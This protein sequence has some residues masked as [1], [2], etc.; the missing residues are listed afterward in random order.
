MNGTKNYLR[1]PLTCGPTCPDGFYPDDATAT[2]KSCIGGC[3]RCETNGIN[4]LQCR[5]DLFLDQSLKRCVSVCPTGFFGDTTDPNSKIC[6]KCNDKC[7]SCTGSTESDC[8]SC[9]TYLGI[10]YF[11][12]LGVAVTGECIADCGNG[13]YGDIVT[14]RC[15]VCSGTCAKCSK[16]STNCTECSGGK[17]LQNNRCDSSCSAGF[18]A[19][20]SDCLPCRSDCATCSGGSACLTCKAGFAFS[21]VASDCVATGNCPNGTFE[22]QTSRVCQS[23]TAPCTHCSGNGLNCTLCEKG[24]S[25]YLFG[26][27]CIANCPSGYFGGSIGSNDNTCRSCYSG[28]SKC[29]DELQTSCLECASGYFF[30]SGECLSVCPNTTIGNSQTRACE[31]CQSGCETCN[32][33][34]TNCTSCNDRYLKVMKDS[35]REKK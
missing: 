27:N 23:C 9:K 33:L 6:V 24:S 20:G 10:D 22:N 32:T 4:C 14:M 35:G 30:H 8:Q 29:T 18:Y 25:V 7:A 15:Q 28:C 21:N 26:N 16:T 5:S 12:A 1:A 3:T 13:N 19:S 2:C 17:V 34:S 11:L 31:P